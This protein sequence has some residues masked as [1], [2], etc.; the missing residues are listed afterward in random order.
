[1]AIQL[2]EA[3]WT[4]ILLLLPMSFIRYRNFYLYSTNSIDD[5]YDH[6]HVYCKVVV[7]KYIPNKSLAVSIKYLNPSASLSSSTKG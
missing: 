6:I 1:M 2:L 4:I 7:D 3:L 5:L